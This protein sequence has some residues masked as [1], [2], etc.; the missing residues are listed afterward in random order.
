MSNLLKQILLVTIGV[1]TLSL[2]SPNLLAQEK[3]AKEYERQGDKA[4]EEGEYSQALE[5]YMLGRR[6][7]K[8]NLTLIYKCGESCLAMKDYDKAEY[9]Y[10]KVLIEND[11]VNINHAFPYLY[12]HLAQSSIY[13][14]N[15][16]QA[17]SFLN[18]C[19]IDCDDI[20]IRKEC[21][22]ELERIDWII[23]NDKPKQYIITNLG[24][25]INNETSQLGSFVLR[26]SIIIFTSTE[27]KKKISKGDTF[28]TDIYNQIFFSFV[29]A[30]YYTPAKKL[31]WG[32]INQKKTNCSDL[33]FDSISST[34]YFTYSKIKNNKK[35]SVIYYSTYS[36]GEWSKPKIFKP[37]YDKN[38]SSCHP[39]IARNNGE[40]FM[41]FTSDREGGYGNMDIWSLDL[42]NKDAKPINLGSTINTSG[43]EI[44]PFYFA[45][46]EELYF[47]S[48]T[49]KGF[50]GFDI[51]RSVGW[52]NRWT[53]VEN[54]LQPINSSYNDIY[55][56]VVDSDIEGYFT[57]NRPTINNKENKTC[58]NDI[59]RFNSEEPETP[60]MTTI[61]KKEGFNPA[62]DLPVALYF[63][64]DSPDAGSEL[65]TTELSYIDCYK[66]YNS[67]SN[68]Y[69]AARTKGLDDS[70]ANIEIAKVESFFKD[71]IKQGYDKLNKALE[72]IQEKLEQGENISIQIRGYSS[73]LFE[74]GYNYNLAER[75][76]VSVENYINT[77]NNGALKPYTQ[78]IATDGKP[79]LETIHL[80][81]GKLEATS[82]NPESIE[83]K[84]QS[85]YLPSSMEERR[86]EI[87][88]IQVRN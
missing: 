24:N 78:S 25:N 76:I 29:D 4:M 12:L 14:G 15:I 9:W 74:T 38:S 66:Q 49:H 27:Y 16:I 1:F 84:R 35:T 63:H 59:Y 46:E 71:K 36:N 23:D 54:L 42:N 45:D 60:T 18:T 65:P 22:R 53:S 34:A 44:T 56:F 81:I 83:E 69:K 30:D 79:R 32:K 13:N 6:F 55:P 21:K 51:F 80:A 43:N 11:T 52:K 39:V 17:Q 86:I 5:Y 68:Q 40:C 7:L 87:K 72:Y 48:D 28:F 41:F 31:E 82:P 33:F 26:D 85:V 20:K 37:V 3:Y 62:F 77:W 88:V 61:V 10:Q 2:S 8:Q 47:A 64:N 75:R 73:S 70:L 50:G 19:L 57:S 58:C 67:L